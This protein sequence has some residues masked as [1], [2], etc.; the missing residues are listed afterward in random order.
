MGIY[1]LLAFHANPDQ[2]LLFVVL[3]V[4][5][6]TILPLTSV[7]AAIIGVLLMVWHHVIGFAR[8]AWYFCFNK[9]RPPVKK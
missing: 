4:G 3:Y 6:E 5:P 2:L 8:K 7:L 9:S 1:N